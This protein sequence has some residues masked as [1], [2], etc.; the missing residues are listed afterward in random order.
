MGPPR[1]G[2]G[3]CLTRAWEAAPAVSTIPAAI[4]RSAAGTTLPDLE[5]RSRRSLRAGGSA[6]SRMH[7]LV[8]NCG[9]ATLKFDLFAAPSGARA[10]SELRRL[11]NGQVERVG[12]AA[13]LKAS[14]AGQ[15]AEARRVDSPDH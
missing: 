12:P 14:F 15:P 13:A 7:L 2:A 9:S 3:A 10:G 6:E 11:A 1:F 8:L 4:Q 5:R